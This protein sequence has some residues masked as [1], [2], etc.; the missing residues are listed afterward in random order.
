MRERKDYLAD[1]ILITKKENAQCVDEI[2]TMRLIKRERSNRKQILRH[3]AQGLKAQKRGL[4]LLAYMEEMRSRY[5]R[6]YAVETLG[7]NCAERR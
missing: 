5:K 4:E 2:T 1:V 7:E 3:K 6:F